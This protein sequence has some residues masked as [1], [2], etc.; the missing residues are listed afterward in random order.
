MLQLQGP[1][2]LQTLEKCLRKSLPESLKVRE[3]RSRGEKGQEQ[4][5]ERQE[6]ERGSREHL[7]RAAL[8]H[9]AAHPLSAGQLC[10]VCRT[11]EEGELQVDGL[12]EV[13]MPAG[14]GDAVAGAHHHLCSV[15]TQS[16]PS[17]PFNSCYVTLEGSFSPKL[18]KPMFILIK[19]SSA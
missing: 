18:A 4:F 8:T 17:R 7:P 12:T 14:S 10:C 15:M 11:K 2:L 3:E 19:Q 13:I 5:E 1:Q 16:F 9:P 6:R